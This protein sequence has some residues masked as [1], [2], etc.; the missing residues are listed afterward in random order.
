MQE[1]ETKIETFCP[2]DR[3]AWRRWLEENH[4]SKASVWIV[5]YRKHTNKPS[6]S[7]SE[8]VDEALCFGWIDSIRKSIDQ[9]SFIQF[10]CPRKPR[11]AWSKINK[12]KVETLIKSGLMTE[13]GYKAIE[14]AKQNGSWSILDEVEE[15]VIPEQLIQQFE[16]HQ[17]SYEYFLGLSRSVKKM[18]LQWIAM[19]KRPETREKR[20]K[21]VAELAGR[22]LKPKQFM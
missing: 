19:A 11:S 7:W 10:F 3:Q 16:I 13:A 4:R 20:I 22:N 8:A 21:E 1:K 9:D 12:A 18:I 17:G 5:Q 15:L 6:I 14:T 2:A